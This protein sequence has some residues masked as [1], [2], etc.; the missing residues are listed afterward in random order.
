MREKD[1]QLAFLVGDL[2]YAM[3]FHADWDAFSQVRSG[4]RDL[5]GPERIA[6]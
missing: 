1:A 2:A 4:A 5:I 3:G 6:S